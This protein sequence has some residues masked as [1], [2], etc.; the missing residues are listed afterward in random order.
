M[1]NRKFNRL[2]SLAITVALALSA[3]LLVFTSVMGNVP[4]PA[5][6][7]S[8]AATPEVTPPPEAAESAKPTTTPVPNPIEPISSAA[9]LGRTAEAGA[10]YVDGI[11]FL[12]DSGLKTLQDGTLTGENAATQ[13]WCPGG[14]KADLNNLSSMTFRSPVT[15]NDVAAGE[16]A[17]VNRPATM[18]LLPSTDNANLLTETSLKAAVKS[19]VESIQVESPETHIILSSLTPI[20]ESYAYEDINFEILNRVNRWLAEAAEENNVKFLDA[21]FE[22]AETNGFLPE[23]FHTGDGMHL[24][25]QG[26]QAWLNCVK[27]HAYIG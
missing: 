14:D 3:A 25:D 27:T 20:A 23:N 18:V 15:G 4:K 8:M 10:D 7:R 24:N 12:G 9:A 16:I 6:E 13:V 26:V 22:L 21:A 17:L 1:N 11:F 19:W 2:W 5:V